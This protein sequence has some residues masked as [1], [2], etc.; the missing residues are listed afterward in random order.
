LGTNDS[1]NFFLTAGTLSQLKE[2]YLKNENKFW[3]DTF[4]HGNYD[5]FWQART[6][7]PYLKNALLKA[8]KPSGP[9]VL[10]VGGWFDAEDLY[11][12]LHVYNALEHGNPGARNTLVM[13]PWSHGGWA[14]GTGEALGNLRFEEKTG[15]WFREQVELPFFN[16]YLKDNGTFPQAAKEADVLAFRTGAN[17]WKRFTEWPPKEAQLKSLYFQASGKLA[18]SAPREAQES[19]DEYISD[20]QKPVPYSALNIG[21]RFAGYMVEDQRFTAGRPD[22]LVYQTEALTE[23]L[24]LAGPIIADLFVS[25]SGTDSDFVVK[26]I[27]VYPDNA[28][29]NDAVKMAGAQMLIRAEI[30]RGKYRHSFSKPEP[31]VPNKPTEV[32]FNLQDLQHTFKAGHKLMVQVQS[33]W[34]PLVDRNPQKFV[35][36]YHAAPSDFQKATQRLYR[37]GNLASNLQVGILK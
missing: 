18:I 20:P 33:S 26:V 16:F 37:A 4:A 9:A 34:F 17:E 21:N 36:I 8:G 13:G 28:P 31:F 12:A 29:A 32:K 7:V 22:V 35:D 2:K 6:P 3:N 23:D 5:E 27:D 1:Y 15:N 10:T 25:T 24:T 14:R 30:M 11:G 19:F